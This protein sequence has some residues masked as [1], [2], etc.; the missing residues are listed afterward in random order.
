MIRAISKK[1]NLAARLLICGL[2]LSACGSDE[3]AIKNVP[4]DR[5]L[6]LGLPQMRDY[7]SFNPFIVGTQSPGFDYLFEPLYFYN[8]YVEKDHL[9][10]WIAERHEYNADYTE[11]TIHIR[12]G[13]QWSDGRP[14]TAHDLKFTI[15][16]LRAHAPELAF[17]TDMDTW[18]AEV[19]VPDSL[20]ARF[21]LKA[22][23]PRFVFSY[24]TYNFGNGIHIV[25]KHIWEGEDPTS[26]KNL[27]LARGLPVVSGPYRLALSEPQ[28]RLW[29]LREDWW[30]AQIGFQ[31]LPRV[32]RIIYL[33][34]GDENK[35]VQLILANQMDQ[36]IDLRPSNIKTLLD[37]NPNVTTWS[38]R[39]LPYGYRDWWPPALGFN[40]LEPPF[41]DPDIRWAVN[42]AI[43]REQLVAIGWQGAGEYTLLPFPPLPA[44][45]ALHRPSS[46][47]AREVSSGKTRPSSD[48][49]YYGTQ[50]LDPRFRG[51]VEQKWRAAENPRRRLS[52]PLPR[53]HARTRRATAPR[54]F[55]RLLPHV[56]RRLH[57]HD[58][59]HGPRLCHGQWRLGARPVLHPPALPQP[60]RPTHRHGHAV[61]LA[62][63]Q[64]GF[65]PLSRSHGPDRAR[66][67]SARAAVSPSP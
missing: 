61:F 45:D 14:W 15:D 10:P 2:A 64:R 58:P 54:G 13:V 7:D 67:S 30:A 22:P 19:Q 25:P 4:R 44:A 40:N 43:D 41:D 59:G 29:D 5:T 18:V 21:V 62:L 57:P 23:N 1:T 8:A 47:L 33:P 63:A 65:R 6:I 20:T 60:L 28:Q 51:S 32:E 9:I 56:L 49:R 16:M 34:Q 17:S 53:L 35:W 48:R 36:C 12:K 31:R 39:Q 52:L 3:G 24:F 66:R 55:R 37:Q 42:H 46:G 38:G 50:G 26:F 27:D 11:A